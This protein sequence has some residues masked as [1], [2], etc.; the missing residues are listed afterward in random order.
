MAGKAQVR[1]VNG[2]KLKRCS[3]PDHPGERWLPFDAFQEDRT[4]ATGRK[5]RCRDCYNAVQRDR[6]D[7]DPDGEAARVRERQHSR[8]AAADERDEGVIDRAVKDARKLARDEEK[9]RA[10]EEAKRKR[11]DSDVAQLRPDDFSSDDDYDVSVGNDKSRGARQLSG[12]ASAAKRQEFNEKM[13]R[14][15]TGVRGAAVAEARG[16]GDLV[17]DMPKG[18]GTYIGELSEQERR[19][20]NRRLA[21]SLSLFAAAE[22][23]SRRLFVTAA[24]QYFSEQIVPVGY[25]KTP[26][27]KPIKRSVCLMLSDLHLGSDLSGVDNPC[28]FGK[29]EEARRLEYILRQAIDYKPQYRENSE[30]VLMW[31]GDLIEGLLLHDLRDGAP[32]AEQKC[33]LWKYALAFIGECSAAFPRVRL[34]WKPGN[35]GRDKVRHP[36][37][38]TSRKWDGHEW[39]MGVALQMAT[40]SLPN[41]TWETDENGV[42]NRAPHSVVDLHGAKFCLTHGDTE[43]KVGDPDTKAKENTSILSGINSTLRYGVKFDAFGFGHYHKGRYQIESGVRILWNGALLP[44]N[45][46]ARTSGYGESCGQFLWEASPGYPVGDVRFIE[47]GKSQDRDEKLGHL[48]KPFRFDLE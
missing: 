18:S 6:Y 22:E 31:N 44:P 25:A 11:L 10:K 21:R 12:A 36:G 37:R 27:K 17:D 30:L 24:R 19:F 5:S 38:A 34:F 20:R 8:S 15:A 9:A 42:L 3:N 45:G 28:P 26:S 39:E 32:L 1:V 47:V 29:L 7:E 48:I 13:A 23:Q 41:V 14:H 16:E 40:A 43:I 46:H 4:S 35:H 33:V 2:R